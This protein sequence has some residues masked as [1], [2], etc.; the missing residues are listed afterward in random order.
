MGIQDVIYWVGVVF[1][2]LMLTLLIYSRIVDFWYKYSVRHALIVIRSTYDQ[3]EDIK[4]A[5]G[6]ITGILW[7]IFSIV[8]TLLVQ[9][10]YHNVWRQ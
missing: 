3:L 4:I 9:S 10:F 1:V 7:S 6:W 8:Y 5:S 2:W